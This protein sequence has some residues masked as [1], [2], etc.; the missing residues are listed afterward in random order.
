MKPSQGLLFSLRVNHQSIIHDLG[1]QGYE[2]TL[3]SRNTGLGSGDGWTKERGAQHPRR[4]G[5]ITCQSGGALAELLTDSRPVSLSELKAAPVEI[6]F[7]GIEMSAQ[8]SEDAGWHRGG[9]NR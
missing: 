3:S 9:E 6:F 2:E 7:S 4:R 1:Q 5:S 8:I